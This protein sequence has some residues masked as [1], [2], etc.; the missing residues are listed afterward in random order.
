MAQLFLDPKNTETT[1]EW[2]PD[3]SLPQSV[4]ENFGR[5]PNIDEWRPGDLLLFHIPENIPWISNLIIKAQRLSYDH[6]DAR[7]HHAAV[8]VGDGYLCEARVHGGVQYRELDDYVG[9][10]WIRVRRDN[11][12][13]DSEGFKLAIRA[14]TRL[15]KSYG[16]NEIAKLSWRA[17][18]GFSARS[19]L[20]LGPK[21]VICSHLYNTAYMAV[22]KRLLWDTDDRP[23]IPAE[24]SKTNILEDVPV[25]WRRIARS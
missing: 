7:W 16:F 18:K 2:R 17:I 10:H 3:R 19:P 5:Y 21:G 6:A 24:L 15:R 1:G 12:M 4:R 8:Y 22:A 25:C 23:I 9:K 20:A 13:S 14:M 11:S